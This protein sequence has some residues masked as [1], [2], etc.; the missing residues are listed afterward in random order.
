MA[1]AWVAFA[2]VCLCPRHAEAITLDDALACNDQAH[3]YIQSLQ[4]R[5][6]IADHPMHIEDDGLNVF[7]PAHD[8]KLMAF[9]MHVFVVL[10]Y[11][12]GD[13]MFEPGKGPPMDGGLY[14]VVV[15]AEPE[16]VAKA[17]AAA[18]SPAEYRR[19]GPFLTALY[20]RIH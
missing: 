5:R 12:Q 14:G 13:P 8:A 10:G 11:Q 4:D 18:G 17:I 20:C 1:C 6:L 7:W 19:A 15:T 3:A 9:E 2:A 16:T